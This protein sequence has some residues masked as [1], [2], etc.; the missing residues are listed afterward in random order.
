MVKFVKDNCET[1]ESEAQKL[2]EIRGTLNTFETYQEYTAGSIE[3]DFDLKQV[4]IDP[5]RHETQ[6]DFLTRLQFENNTPSFKTRTNSMKVVEEQSLKDKD[7]G[8]NFKETFVDE[9]GITREV[10]KDLSYS[11]EIAVLR[12]RV[13]AQILKYKGIPFNKIREQEKKLGINQD[14][15]RLQFSRLDSNPSAEVVESPYRRQ[16]L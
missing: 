1:T 16:N 9:Q 11:E 5:S 12:K 14:L 6:N 15:A 13:Q 3:A 4:N 8:S 7:D 10:K 2:R